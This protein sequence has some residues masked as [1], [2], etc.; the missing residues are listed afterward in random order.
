MSIIAK[1]KAQVEVEGAIRFG[2]VRGVVGIVV[3]IV[4]SACGYTCHQVI[5]DIVAGSVRLVE[6]GVYGR[7]HKIKRY[8][9]S[10]V[11]HI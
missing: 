9:K 6:V 4:G 11:R 8:K 3:G 10:L 2:Y 1:C 7:N 5:V